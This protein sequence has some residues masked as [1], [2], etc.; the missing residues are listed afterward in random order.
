MN[1]NII[2]V[3]NSKGLRI[4]KTLIDEYNIEETVEL[5]LK[6]DCIEI[7]PK[8][9]PRENWKSQ[10]QKMANNNDDELLIPDVFADEDL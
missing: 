8:R 7:R 3:G 4:P 6:H 10:F 5:T 9:K 1:I 2:K